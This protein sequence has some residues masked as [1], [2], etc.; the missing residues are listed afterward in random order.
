M[1]AHD[2]EMNPEG[3]T[4]KIDELAAKAGVS[5]RTVRYYVQRGLLPGPTFKGKDTA[6]S[7][8]HLVRLRAIRRLQDDHLPLE[9][10]R[11]EIA[12][13]T[14]DELRQLVES[15]TPA[16]RTTRGPLPPEPAPRSS[17]DERAVSGPSRT[18]DK[19]RWPPPEGWLVWRLADG[20]ELHLAERAD[21]IAHAWADEIIEWMA[22]RSAEGQDQ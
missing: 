12:R 17:G 11:T 16:W 14:P 9:A 21:E 15:A 7:H 22:R 2:G 1:I 18:P 8:E 5:P 3:K 10:I 13:R 6:Y 19:P 4:Y 20:L